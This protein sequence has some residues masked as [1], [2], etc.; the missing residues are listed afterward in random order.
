MSIL[1]IRDRDQFLKGTG[2]GAVGIELGLS[3]VVGLVAG[4]FLDGYFET[5]RVFLFIG[6]ALGFLSGARS[7]YRVVRRTQRELDADSDSLPEPTLGDSDAG[8]SVV[9]ES[10]SRRRPR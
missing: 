7:I 9:L 4:R 5:G 2:V 6:L 1:G 8:D 10:V 3:I